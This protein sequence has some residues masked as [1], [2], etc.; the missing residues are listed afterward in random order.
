MSEH[1]QNGLTKTLHPIRDSF[2]E[3]V[4]TQFFENTHKEVS[5]K[6][7]TGIAVDWFQS[8]KQNNILGWQSFPY[9]DV[10]TGNTNYIES[11]LV[12]YGYDGFQILSPHE[13]A[14]YMLIGK[15]GNTIDNLEPN[16]PLIISV[17]NWEYGGLRPNWDYLLKMCEQKSIDIHLDLA[18]LTIARNIEIDL[19]H[20]CIKSVAMSTSKYSQDWVRAGIR[21]SKQRTMDSVTILNHYYSHNNTALFTAGAY[22]MQNIPRDYAWNTYKEKYSAIAKQLN[23]H[24]T[25]LI[26][27]VK[28]KDTNEIY[29]VAKLLENNV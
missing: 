4:K 15:S 5:I 17:P 11:F 14:Y 9:V 1:N 21:W 6:D 24:E 3:S 19:S 10:T 13:Y 18:W 27:V 12:R 25:C 28:D 8:S 20:P 23:V 2:L 29:G 22:A 16:K 7:Y 26:N